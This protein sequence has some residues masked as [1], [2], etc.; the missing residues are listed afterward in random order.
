MLKM[1]SLLPNQRMQWTIITL[2]F[3]IP[4]L[5][6]VAADPVRYNLYKFHFFDSDINFINLDIK[7]YKMGN[8]IK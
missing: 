7:D 3:M 2:R 8:E 4:L 5:C 1:V 6:L